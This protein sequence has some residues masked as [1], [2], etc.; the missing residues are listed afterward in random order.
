VLARKPSYVSAVTACARVRTAAVSCRARAPCPAANGLAPHSTCPS[1]GPSSAGASPARRRAVAPSSP[2]PPNSAVPSPMT[3]S[4][5]W[6]IWHRSEAPI[7]PTSGIT[8]CTRASSRSTSSRR[9]SGRT[10]LPPPAMPLTRAR[11]A[12]RTTGTGSG[13]P[14]ALAR[15]R[16]VRTLKTSSSSRGSAYDERAPSP[17]VRPYAGTWRS[18]TSST[19]ARSRAS[20]GSTSSARTTGAPYRA[21]ATTSSYDSVR[22]STTTTVPPVVPV[23][24][25]ATSGPGHAPR[26]S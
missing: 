18:T 21:T 10:P 15:P 1:L 19:T 23:T 5:T 3:T 2:S 24:R 17:V 12:A 20:R 22:P 7:D 16:T 13:S 9:T 6:A 14:T 25:T 26:P 4:P 8:G 11:S